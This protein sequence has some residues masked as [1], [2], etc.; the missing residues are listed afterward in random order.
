MKRIVMKF[1]GTSVANVGKIQAVADRVRF[2]VQR[3][4]QVAVVVSAMGKTTD[5]LLKM[6]GAL[7]KFDSREIDQ[8]LATGEQQ[9]IALVAMALGA[10]EIPSR[11]YTGP[12]AG[13][14]A[15]GYHMEGRICRLQ[16]VLLEEDMEEGIVPVVAGFQAASAGST[17]VITLGRGGSD[18]S[19]V[20]LACALEAE[21]CHIY[22][23]VPGVYTTD[24]R[25]V[26]EALKLKAIS[27]DLCM[28]MAALGAKVLQARS[29]EMASRYGLAVYVGSSFSDEEG[30]WVMKSDVD[31]KLYVHSVVCDRNV[32]KV[33]VLGVPDEPGI[34]AGFFTLLA[35]N[36][37][38]VEM[39]IQ[40]VMRG[41]MNDIAF[42][43]R[44]ED[45]G[46]A[47]QV[48]REYV[49][50]V[51]AQG[52]NFDTEI[53]R[54]SVV[55]AGIGNHP[56]VPYQMFAVFADLGINIDMIS[57]TALTITCVVEANRVEEAVK[58]LHKI[59][60]EEQAS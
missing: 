60:V 13:I 32:A 15:E 6:A 53:A 47:T 51:G 34:A 16:P 58:A 55:G 22:T 30:T 59:F 19:A 31:E 27:Y 12:Q 50:K 44:K 56:E 43:V 49:E 4:Y 57:S 8:L 23:D 29:V 54:V 25:I 38:P 39:I 20:A 48:T 17:D 41:D 33:A 2:F 28:E 35:K 14:L 1:G 26:P 10:L 3:G 7:G 46:K 42:L 18:L 11:S 40:S 21:E 24:P 5:G 36:G 37:I 9:T 45:L 52:V